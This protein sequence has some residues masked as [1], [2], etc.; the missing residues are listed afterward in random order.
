MP[1]L[2]N[3]KHELF[4]Q[5][6]AKGQSQREAYRN[7]GYTCSTKPDVTDAAA[8][9]LLR[10][11]RVQAR[12]AELQHNAAKRAEITLESW[13]EEG[14]ELMRAA[15]LAGDHTAASQQYERVA[16]V[17]GF[18]VEKSESTQTLRGFSAQPVTPEQWQQQYAAD[19]QPLN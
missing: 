2:D 11:V 3:P 13:I 17:A 18:W 19:S 7:A 6:I 14:A 16:K 4:A 1:T 5:G 12:V 8:S 9:R 10:D 15:K